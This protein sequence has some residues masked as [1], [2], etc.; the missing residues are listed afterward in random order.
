MLVY[1]E[2]KNEIDIIKAQESELI[3]NIADPTLL[4]DIVAA[5]VAHVGLP[6]N[7]VSAELIIISKFIYDNYSYLNKG[8]IELAYNMALTGKLEDVKYFGNFSPLYVGKVLTAYTR[9]R[10]ETLIEVYNRKN[11]KEMLEQDSKPS[12]Q[13]Q[14]D[15]TKQIIHD[16]YV[17]FKET[18]EIDDPFS[19]CYNYLFKNEL[20]K[21]TKEDVDSAVKW[22]KE[23]VEAIKGNMNAFSG[24]KINEELQYKRWAR[25]WCVQKFFKTV[26]INI[27]LNNIIP[28]Q[29]T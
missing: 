12:P 17:A 28:S 24:F 25:S 22:G 23:K 11:K 13:E 14:A 18:G 19:L 5:W 27:L 7:D 1:A 15:L 4:I 3:R 8:E 16:F 20:I 10:K 6:K 9:Y 26:D 29:F 2:N 21:P